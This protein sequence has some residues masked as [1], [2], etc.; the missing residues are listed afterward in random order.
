MSTSGSADFSQ[1]C[2]EIIRDALT[3]VNGIDDDETPTDH[4]YQF[5]R[6]A[7][8]RLA[9]SWM[10]RGLKLWSQKTATLDLVSG[11][12]SYTLGATGTKVMTRPLD[13]YNVRW[14][15]G[16]SELPV[17]AYSRNEY[18]MQVN[19]T[20]TGKPV[21]FYYDPQLDNGVLYLWP[22]PDSS[23][24]DLLFNYRTPIEDFDELDDDAYFPV[25]WTHALVMNLC[26]LIF[27]LGAVDAQRRSELYQQ[28]MDALT[29]AEMHDNDDESVFLVPQR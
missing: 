17:L 10:K 20:S 15:D 5:A 25:E 6:R 2:I 28:A 27:P 16:T 21:R 3:L 9:K 23:T 4:Q 18:M 19:K 7:L 26:T 8:N 24:D 29:E 12:N 14:T 13:V 22:A 11:T 1:S